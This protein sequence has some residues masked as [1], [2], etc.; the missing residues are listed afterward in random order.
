MDAGEIRAINPGRIYVKAWKERLKSLPGPGGV[1]LMH[2]GIKGVAAG[3][4]VDKGFKGCPLK[5]QYAIKA[6]VVAVNISTEN[7]LG[8]IFFCPLN[9]RNPA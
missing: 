9:I 2:K 1:L 8:L 3:I 7:E 4:V 5:L 6:R